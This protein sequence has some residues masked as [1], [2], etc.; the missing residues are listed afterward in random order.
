MSNQPRILMFLTNAR[1][2]C[3]ALALEML[4]KSGSLPVF[5]RVVFL[6]NNVSAQHMRFVDQF[7]AAHPETKFDKVLGPGTRPE[8]I[9]WMQNECIRRYPGGL[10]M[11]MDEDVFVPTG[12]AQ[13]MVEAYEANRH[14]DNLALISPLIPNNAMGLHQLLTIFYPD[15]LAQ[16]RQM[17]N[18]EPDPKRDGP[19]WYSPRTAEWST[20]AFL[21]ID[22][23]NT[24]HREL[25]V[26][27]GEDRYLPFGR[28]FSI[29]CIAYDH[30][31]VERMGGI[32]KTDEPGWCEW[33]E[34]NGQ[35]HVLDRSQIVLHYS[36]FVQQNMLDRSSLLE[37][38]RSTNL[39]N[40]SSWSQRLHLSRARRVVGQISTS[41][42]SLLKKRG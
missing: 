38:I 11:K 41:V 20:R 25:L 28:P 18:R 9:S 14:R 13:R 33:V 19:I 22:S 21:N 42:S 8:G 3:A 23:A 5:D 1:R 36:F 40:S 27:K 12:W 37:D 30:R 10:Y 29:G 34:K 32:P 17:F 39:P 7:I 24:R 2:D 31:H 16:Y 26:Q 6:L 4:E 15:L 35:A